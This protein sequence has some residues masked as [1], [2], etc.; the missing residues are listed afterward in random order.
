MIL[1]ALILQAAAPQSAV[2]AERAFNAAA[3]AK[4]QWTAFREYAAEGATM[5]VPQPVKAQ[6]WLKDRK[7]PPRSITW[8]PTES[9]VSCDGN[10]A[11]NS[12][13]VRWPGGKVGYFTTVWKRQVDGS[14][15]W[16]LD[17]GD[18]LKSDRGRPV[19]PKLVRASCAPLPQPIMSSILS[20]PGAKLGDGASSDGTIRWHWQVTPDGA[21]IFTVWIWNGDAFEV[22]VSDGV[23][24]PK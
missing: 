24:A 11:V 2:D 8:W 5:L 15:Q 7:D 19:E 22:C 20:T 21:R 14:W 18:K 23:A 3:Q 12:G 10:Y 13:G 6:D 1:A 4:G 17:H 9:Y 16:R